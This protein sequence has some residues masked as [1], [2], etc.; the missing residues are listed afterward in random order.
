M[1]DADTLVVDR[2][3]HDAVGRGRDGD[4]QGQGRQIGR[5]RDRQQQARE[6]RQ[7]DRQGPP[8][9]EPGD[10][11]RAELQPDD[12]AGVEPEERQRELPVGQPELGLER[13]DARRPG[14]EHQ[15]GEQERGGGTQAG[16]P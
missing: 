10:H 9:A 7:P 8:A 14:A 6:D 11:R 5:V 1:L 3:V 13:R 12:G 16:P 4:G 2:H 15:P